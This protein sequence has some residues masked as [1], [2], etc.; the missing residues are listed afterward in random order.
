MRRRQGSPRDPA[1]GR[2]RFSGSQDRRPSEIAAALRSLRAQIATARRRGELH[3][4]E[5]QALSELLDHV[6]AL[7]GE[8]N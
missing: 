3:P 4:E 1:L 5:R 6:A 7:L 8:G 2:D